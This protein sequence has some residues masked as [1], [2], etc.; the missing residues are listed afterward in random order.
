MKQVKG[1]FC[2]Q[3]EVKK[4]KFIA[5]IFEAKQL[6]KRREELWQA[7]PKAAH[8]VWATRHLNEFLQVVENSSDDGEPKGSSGVSVLNA[9]RGGEFVDAAVAVVRYF[10]GVKLGVGGLVRAYSAAANEVIARCVGEGGAVE[11][12]PREEFRC[13]VPFALVAKVAHHF[14]KF[15]FDFSQ[16]WGEGG[17][18]F[19]MF[20]TQSQSAAAAEFLRE[21][22]LQLSKV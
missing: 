13:F 3:I 6:A 4:S 10:G 19:A 2:A 18:E 16:N 7:H 1:E 8:I 14:A 12:V 9:L 20:L 17:A 11:F 15:E 22:N 21:F 5:H